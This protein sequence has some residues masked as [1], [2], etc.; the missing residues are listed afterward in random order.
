MWPTTFAYANDLGFDVLVRPKEAG[1]APDRDLV[2]WNLGRE[3]AAEILR[4]RP[5]DV[6]VA[7]G[8]LSV[9]ASGGTDGQP[10]R[11]EAEE[12]AG[13]IETR[14]LASTATQPTADR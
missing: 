9:R 8:S 13:R 5:V 3:R 10:S 6:A 1:P 11:R 14:P 7:C 2:A 12:L 4:T